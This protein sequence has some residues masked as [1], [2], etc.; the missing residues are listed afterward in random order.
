MDYFFTGLPLSFCLSDVVFSQRQGMWF[1]P[2]SLFA[3]SNSVV[4]I[5][6]LV[7]QVPNIYGVSDD[8]IVH[9]QSIFSESGNTGAQVSVDAIRIG[10][11]GFCSW[12]SGHCSLVLRALQP[13]SPGFPAIA[14]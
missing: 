8:E 5:Y 12:F 13:G 6:F 14:A 9:Y 4:C 10:S 11:Y 1:S 3:R 2:W 7:V